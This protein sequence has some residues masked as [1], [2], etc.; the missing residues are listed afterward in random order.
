M[1]EMKRVTFVDLA[2]PDGTYQLLFETAEPL[3]VVPGDLIRVTGGPT[4][5]R[6]GVAAVAVTHL[7]H[8]ARWNGGDFRRASTS[9]A[10]AHVASAG[11]LRLQAV[12]A[13]IDAAW[14]TMVAEGYQPM[15]TDLLVPRY[16]GGASEPIEAR[17]GSDRLGF[18]RITMEERMLQAIGA[19]LDS[20]F[21]IGPIVKGGREHIFL[22][23][24]RTD[25]TTDQLLATILRV[26][27]RVEGGTVS[28]SRRSLLPLQTDHCQQLLSAMDHSD[29]PELEVEQI[30]RGLVE[31][32]RGWALVDR[33]PVI[34]SPLYRASPTDPAVSTRARLYVDGVFVADLGEQETDL[35][36]VTGRLAAQRRRIE[37]R[38][39][40]NDP[41]SGGR[42]ILE[43]LAAGVPPC[44]GFSIRL[45][46]LIR[47]R[48][49]RVAV[50]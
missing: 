39:G 30:E 15:V 9:P 38:F 2:A 3:R 1:R 27:E 14:T 16:N 40:A 41:R 29:R 4:T 11:A 28:L 23:G 43:V 20:V 31:D 47:R 18:I 13:A 48:A 36:V 5:T 19:G 49:Q 10:T 33:L 24:Y 35:G 6:T 26:I 44:A 50:T 46:E 7:E 32:E 45:D 37:R 12:S 17:M 34:A 42:E 8:R 22:E 21:Q 25:A